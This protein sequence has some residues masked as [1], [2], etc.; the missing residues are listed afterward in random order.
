MGIVGGEPRESRAS[1]GAKWRWSDRACG[2]RDGGEIALPSGKVRHVDQH[3]VSRP[4]AQPI[5]CHRRRV[6][7]PLC[8]APGI[9]L[10]LARRG[11]WMLV[12]WPSDGEDRQLA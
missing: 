12:S 1:T 10:H 11:V 4:S 6:S 8:A 9:R 2:P 7:K 3:Q 5:L